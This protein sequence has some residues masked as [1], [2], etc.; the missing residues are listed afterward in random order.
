MAWTWF[1][2]S[3]FDCKC[4]CGHNN[5]KD[6]L[7]NAMD[8]ARTLAGIPFIVTSGSRCPAHNARVST[9]GS[10]SPH[11]HG[12]AADISAPNSH[13]RWLIVG[14]A[15]KSGFNR[16]GLGPN[17]IHLDISTEYAQNVIWTY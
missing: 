6:G 2:E 8:E 4:G 11:L 17:F 16:I 9:V 12:L 3:E 14:A 1:T 7:I 5:V 10:T 15:I 13:T